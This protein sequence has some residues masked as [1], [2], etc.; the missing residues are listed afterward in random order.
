M[1]LNA[2]GELTRENF[3]VVW[4]SSFPT[5]RKSRKIKQAGYLFDRMKKKITIR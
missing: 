2:P 3:F 4:I 1:S 5:L